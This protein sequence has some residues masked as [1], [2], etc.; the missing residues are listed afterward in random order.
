MY[1]WNLLN[2]KDFK[3]NNGIYSFR[4]F[5]PHFPKRIFIYN[6]NRLFIFENE[7]AFNPKG[8]LSEFVNCID[9]LELTNAQT[10]KYSKIIADYLDKEK[11]NLYGDEV[12]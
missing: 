10:I 7:G 8:V 5:G 3:F 2:P 11:G 6:K 9:K 4:G 12:K 1:I